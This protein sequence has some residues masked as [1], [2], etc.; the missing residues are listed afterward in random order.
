MCL[1]LNDK[2]QETQKECQVV[3][4]YGDECNQFL[5][6]YSGKDRGNSI[7]T[8]PPL[9]IVDGVTQYCFNATLSSIDI[10][11]TINTTIVIQGT[12]NIVNFSG[13]KYTIM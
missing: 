13:G 1:F 10:S 3:I 2:I 4:T 8:T 12:I 11:I 6:V 7:E 9:Q 5:N